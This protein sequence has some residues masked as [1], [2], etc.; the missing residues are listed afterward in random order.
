MIANVL[1]S[2]KNG[3][4]QAPRPFPGKYPTRISIQ[5]LRGPVFNYTGKL[6]PAV[7]DAVRKLYFAK[8]GHPAYLSYKEFD[9]NG[10]IMEL[11]RG[12]L[13]NY[14]GFAEWY[15]PYC[16]N[17]FSYFECGTSLYYMLNRTPFD[18]DGRKTTSIALLKDTEYGEAEQRMVLDCAKAR[19]ARDW[20]PGQTYKL[21]ARILNDQ[22]LDWMS[23]RKAAVE[24]K[25][26]T[27]FAEAVRALK[28]QAAQ[29]R[30]AFK[31]PEP[32][33]APAPDTFNAVEREG[34][35]FFFK[36]P[37]FEAAMLAFQKDMLRAAV[38]NT[39]IVQTQQQEAILP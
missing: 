1:G 2:I 12:A 10:L 9:Q 30:V 29:P 35:V 25:K 20:F 5:S 8:G 32:I 21:V 37:G 11:Q 24:K 36:N 31:R 28:K 4:S 27:A 38:A 22:A 16:R 18:C 15:I 14:V 23:V 33:P 7:N 39:A 13:N 3:L 26:P 17:V 34:T 19:V 6:V